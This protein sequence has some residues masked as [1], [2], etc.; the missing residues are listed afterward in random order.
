MK[1]AGF[2]HDVYLHHKA[3]HRVSVQARTLP[4]RNKA[5]EI[6]GSIEIFVD[7]SLQESMFRQLKELERGLYQDDLS[8]IGNWKFAEMRL[9]EL[10]GAFHDHGQAF[11]A[12]FID[13]D[14]FKCV[15]DNYGHL[16]G[17]K[18]IQL[19]ARSLLKGLR[20]TDRVCRFGGDEFVCLLRN[21]TVEEMHQAAERLRKLVQQ[22]ELDLSTGTLQV[23]VSIGGAMCRHGDT[24]LAVIERADQSL[25]RAKE[26][27]RNRVV[28]LQA[29]DIILSG[30][31]SC[32]RSVVGRV[33][34]DNSSK[35]G[36]S[37]EQ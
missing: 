4:L 9:S 24:S 18:I 8:G 23:S 37:L 14:H 28:I 19:V 6:A 30:F 2:K 7:T 33:T 21:L 29:G 10:M 22:S 5:G 26:L 16:A 27:G 31:G 11:G 36:Q 13:I 20:P 12:L 34:N 32:R 17:D 3:G 25:Y 35:S 1:Q 15:N